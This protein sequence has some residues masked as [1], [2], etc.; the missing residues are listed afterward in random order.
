MFWLVAA[1]LFAVGE[2]TSP[3]SFFLLPFAV[4]AVAALAASLLGAG[5]LIDWVLFLAVAIGALLAL[6]PLARRLDR[7]GEDQGVGARRLIGQ[8]AVVTEAIPKGSV[9]VARIRR[10]DWRAE[11]FDG[12]AIPVGA[13]VRVTDV[14][15]TRVLVGLLDTDLTEPEGD[16]APPATT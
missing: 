4:G 14:D 2:M 12:T 6:R 5:L 13:R 10:E 3:G 11:A 16:D 8:S 9:G 15:G 7:D 1:V